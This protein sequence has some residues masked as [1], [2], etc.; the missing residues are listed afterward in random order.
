ML[1]GGK[2]RYDRTDGLDDPEADLPAVRPR[3]LPW[4][5]LLKRSTGID[6]LLCPGCGAQMIL[7]ALIT[8][9]PVVTRILDHLRIPSTAPPLAPARLP[10]QQSELL[11][12]DLEQTAGQPDLLDAAPHQALDTTA[13]LARAPP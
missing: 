2:V 11:A 12:D 6:G 8:A 10:A 13:V 1:P 9:P 4:A 7:L 3:R 5:S